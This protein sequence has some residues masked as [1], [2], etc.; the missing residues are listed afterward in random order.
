M[1]YTIILLERT[2]NSKFPNILLYIFNSIINVNIIKKNISNSGPLFIKLTQWMI[3]YFNIT[4]SDKY[5]WVFQELEV[6]YDKCPLHRDEITKNIYN[7]MFHYFIY[8]NNNTNNSNNEGIRIIYLY[9][10]MKNHL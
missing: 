8:I 10:K 5:K 1:N 2:P 3:P 4:A 6:L 7:T 9:Y